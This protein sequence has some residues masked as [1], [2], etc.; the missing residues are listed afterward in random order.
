[1]I[2]YSKKPDAGTKL[3]KPISNEEDRQQALIAEDP[4]GWD[5]SGNDIDS[6]DGNG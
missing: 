1:M 5:P 4:K 3:I 2:R 6:T